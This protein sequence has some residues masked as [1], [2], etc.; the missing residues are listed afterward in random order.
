MMK[1]APLHRRTFLKGLGTAVAL[2]L[3]DCMAPLRAAAAGATTKTPVRMA[4]FFVPNG[5]NMADWTPSGEG[6]NF[7]LPSI[8]APLNPLKRDVLVLS[9]LAQDKG[10]ANG[11]GPGDHARSAASFLT[12]VQPLKSEGSQIRAG[13]SADQYVAE[14]IAS[15][16]RFGSLEMGIESGRQAGKCDSGYSCAYSNNISWRN[17]STPMTKETNP[18]LVFERFFGNGNDGESA[19]SFLR[20][21]EFKKSILDYVMD[22][23]RRLNSQ[24]SGNDREKI[25]EYLT[26]V[27]E[28]ERR[29]ETAEQTSARTEQ[30][31]AGVEKPTGAPE[32]MGEHIR[33]MGDMMVLAFQTDLTRVCTFMIAN[34]GSNRAY[35]EIAV[36]DGHHSLSHH[37]GD[38]VKL[39]K[40]ARINHYHAEQVAY[41]V[42][43]LKNI[44]EGDGSILDH[45]MIVYGAGIGDGNRHNHDDL[46]IVLIGRGGGTIRTGRHL[47]Y[48]AETPLNNLYLSMMDRMGVHTNEFGDA[49][50]RLP[51]LEG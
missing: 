11:D 48:E 24:V 50:G 22:D 29:I 21:R 30:V 44:K 8:L 42:K 10:R 31:I 7:V 2:P 49:T 13:I 18:R 12:G 41:I 19:N 45:S 25:D 51:G 39:D 43:R 46:P 1:K 27:R 36:S 9:G 28:I 3:L 35:R 23:A 16:T 6:A 38:P 5:V 34:E 47:Q 17:E 4:F 26:A 32:D 20:R 14:H 37:Q 33:L 15:E 40:I